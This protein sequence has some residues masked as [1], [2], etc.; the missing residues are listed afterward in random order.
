MPIVAEQVNYGH[1][2]DVIGYQYNLFMTS[3]FF[4]QALITKKRARKERA[5]T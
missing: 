2:H 5:Y 1:C 4:V 3:K